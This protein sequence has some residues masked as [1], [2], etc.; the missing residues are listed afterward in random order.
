MAGRLG[1]MTVVQSFEGKRFT[2][3]YRRDVTDMTRKYSVLVLENTGEPS[4]KT[5]REIQRG[6]RQPKGEPQKSTPFFVLTIWGRLLV[7]A[8]L[9]GVLTLIL[10]YN[11]TGGDTGFESFMDSESLGVRLV[12]TT[13]GIIITLFWTSYFNCK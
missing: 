12:F 4:M 9:C 10:V 5:P 1:S 7:M 6:R 3:D 11:N 2:L 8:V 13:V